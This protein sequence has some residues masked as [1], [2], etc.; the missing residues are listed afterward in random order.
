MFNMKI[1]EHKQLSS[2][3]DPD[4]IV[5]LG[6]RESCLV[7]EGT[8]EAISKWT[9]QGVEPKSVVVEGIIRWGSFI[10]LLLIFILVPNGTTYDQ[11][12]WIMLNLLGQLNVK[13]SQWIN[14]ERSL[15]R[16][17]EI[18]PQKTETRTHVW[19]F[20]LRQFNLPRVK[21]NWVDHLNIPKTEVWKIWQKKV[22]E[23]KKKDAKKLYDEIVKELKTK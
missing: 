14:T 15:Q 1:A 7:L 6:R 10:V 12:A 22:T 13:M 11:M 4:E 9:G 5:I 21:S 3:K 20:L 23:E 18:T 2:P 19:G 8:R 16:L 17:T